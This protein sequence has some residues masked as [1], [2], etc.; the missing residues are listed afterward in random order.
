MQWT[1]GR[2][3]VVRAVAAVAG[4][5]LA[6]VPAYSD[7]EAAPA[8]P[9][10]DAAA[11][12]GC[13]PVPDDATLEARG[14]RIRAVEIEVEDIFDQEVP[15]ESGGVYR[16]VNRLHFNTR[17]QVAR[18]LLLVR[19]GDLY[20]RRLLDESE[21]LLRAERYFSDAV[22][23]PVA[24]CG[25][26]VDLEVAVHDVW[27][28]YL[29]ASFSRSGGKN[30]TRFEI[31]DGNFLGLGKDVAIEQR[32]NVDRDSLLARYRD[33][34]VR[35]SRLQLQLWYA[36]NSDGSFQVFDLRKPFY[37][38]DTRQA[39]GIRVRIDDRVDDLYRLGEI[40]TSFRHQQDFVDAFIGRSAGLRNGRAVRWTVGATLLRDRFEKEFA[41]VEPIFIP[42]DRTL[43]YPWLG[44]EWVEDDFREVLDFDQIA[45][46]EDLALGLRVA[47]R[48]GYSSEAWGGDED[49]A[50]FSLVASNGLEWG[51][52]SLLLLAGSSTGRWGDDGAQN[53]VTGGQARLYW[54]NFGKQLFFATLG[55]DWAENL[56]FDNQLL[57]GG[58]NGLRGYPLRYQE[59]DRRALLTLEQRFY[60]PLDLFHV[61]QVGG[62]VFFDI[63]RAWFEEEPRFP[64]RLPVKATGWLKDVGLGL[65]LSS[66]RSG[67]GTM[68]HFDV[69]FP[70]DGDDSIE[71]VQWLVSTKE[72]F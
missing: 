2:R 61:V 7:S 41:E 10:A 39:A 37:A 15:E 32:S 38:L 36:D 58:D 60:T 17:P 47:G 66:N 72:T 62:A 4:L 33:S 68:V 50:V 29:A 46:T 9:A 27:T 55:G 64:P 45:R 11:D 44:F 12:V 57:L 35:G 20:R 14:A 1:H 49:R 25:N 43:L 8:E 24:Y 34:S 5:L 56:D 69:A 19:P 3:C 52:D 53:T 18:N 67:Q 30:A 26:E 23:R 16:L 71:D 31:E 28:L 51:D 65:R 54:R 70:L 13:E 6:A 48:I 59:G 63:G 42:P 21:R 22:I 40:Y